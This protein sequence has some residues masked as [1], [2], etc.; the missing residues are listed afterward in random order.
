MPLGLPEF[1]ENQENRCPVIF[2][3][4]PTFRSSEQKKR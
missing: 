1:I 3:L 2:V 4:D